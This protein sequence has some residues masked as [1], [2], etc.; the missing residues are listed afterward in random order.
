M[1]AMILSFFDSL[2]TAGYLTTCTLL[3]YFFDRG[4]WYFRAAKSLNQILSEL[5]QLID[6]VLFVHSQIKWL[7][8]LLKSRR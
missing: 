5:H 2:L 6:H 4:C 8:A 1:L 7:I 3:V